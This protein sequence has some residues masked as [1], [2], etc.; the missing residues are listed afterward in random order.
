MKKHTLFFLLIL[1]GIT[2]SLNEIH[3]QKRLFR[4]MNGK[5]MV[6]DTIKCNLT[7]DQIV[8]RLKPMLINLDFKEE[9]FALADSMNVASLYA[10]LTDHLEMERDKFTSFAIMM[11]YYL[12]FEIKDN[13]CITK[14]MD[15]KYIDTD[16]Y[17]KK[18]KNNNYDCQFY[19]G[20]MVLLKKQYKSLFVKNASDKIINHTVL[21]INEI[22]ANVKNG[23]KTAPAK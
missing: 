8:Q 21:R 18:V 3:A 11:N 14:I 16:E 12:S 6:S 5:I 17:Q 15:N 10:P 19:P 9:Q 4:M 23:L 13:Q 2:F 1:L 20:E 7:K 22:F